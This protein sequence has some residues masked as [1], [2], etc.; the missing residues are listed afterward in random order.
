VLDALPQLTGML[1]Q[2][3]PAYSAKRVG[4]R[5]AYALARAGEEVALAPAPVRVDGWQVRAWRD[6]TDDA[7][8]ELDARVTC[9]PGTYVRSLA[10][11]LGRLTG[12][13]A[14]LSALRRTRSGVFDVADAVSLDAL[15]EGAPRLRPARD[16]IPEYPTQALDAAD[17]RRVFAGNAVAATASGARAALVDAASGRLVAVA[18]RAGDRWQ[19][20]V[21]LHD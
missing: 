6:A 8:A 15:C 16:A 10:R 17:L 12:S 4:G 14:H 20:R 13:A 7:P 18:E 5:R 21:V 19:P 2:L 1:D 3:P 11:D 9:G